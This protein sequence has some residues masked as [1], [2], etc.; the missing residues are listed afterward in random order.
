MIC[1]TV[2]FIFKSIAEDETETELTDKTN[3]IV[4]ND[5]SIKARAYVKL[6]SNFAQ[7]T[8]TYFSRLACNLH[9]TKNISPP[10]FPFS[11]FPPVLQKYSVKKFTCLAFIFGKQR[12]LKSTLCCIWLLTE[13]TL[14]L[15]VLYMTYP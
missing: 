4:H 12:E 7:A 10:F 6:E 5:N 1:L 13:T 8:I 11:N 15:S 2:N 14:S 3:I 9:L